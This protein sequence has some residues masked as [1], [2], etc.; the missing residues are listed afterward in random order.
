MESFLL[1]AGASQGEDDEGDDRRQS[2]PSCSHR[3]ASSFLQTNNNMPTYQLK[4]H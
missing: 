2:Q 4:T 1:A 3:G